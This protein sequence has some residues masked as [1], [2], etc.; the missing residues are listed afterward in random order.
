MKVINIL[1]MYARGI[2]AYNSS[3]SCESK[4]F[5]R[6]YPGRN[7][8]KN[9]EATYLNQFTNGTPTQ[10]SVGLSYAGMKRTAKI[11]STVIKQ[12]TMFEI[13]ACA[14]LKDNMTSLRRRNRLESRNVTSAKGIPK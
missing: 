12:I 10:K 3:E 4:I 8:A 14:I 11:N 13:L 5:R 2:V 9:M 1:K 6:K 7:I